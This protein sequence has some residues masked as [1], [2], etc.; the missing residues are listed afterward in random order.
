M[1]KRIA[2][3]Y[4]TVSTFD[5]DLSELQEAGWQLEKWEFAPADGYAQQFCIVAVY[6]FTGSSL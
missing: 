5:K 2:R 4:E 3:R 1:K 6:V